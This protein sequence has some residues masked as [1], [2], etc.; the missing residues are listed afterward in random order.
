MRLLF[1]HPTILWRQN[2]E[3]GHKAFKAAVAAFADAGHECEVVSV[4]SHQA[5]DA[6][7]WHHLSSLP[8][9]GEGLIRFALAPPSWREVRFAALVRRRVDEWR[10]DRVIL[11]CG[12]MDARIALLLAGQ[13]LAMSVNTTAALPFGPR[14]ASKTKPWSHLPFGRMPRIFCAS[15]YIRDYIRAH[16]GVDAFVQPPLAYGKGPYPLCGS[17][18]PA[19]ITMINPIPHKGS[20]VFA[21]LARRYPDRKFRA[22]R[23][24]GDEPAELKRLSNVEI[25]PP[26]A[27]LDDVM[28]D[29]TV[30][31]VPSMWGEGWANVCVDA[32]LRGVPVLASDD[33]GLAEGTLGIGRCVPTLP[34]RVRLGAGRAVHF[35]E[36]RIDLDAWAR[37]L[38]TLVGDRAAWEARSRTS[39]AA[40]LAF[41]ESLSVDKLASYLAA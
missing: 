28:R 24:Y 6:S 14:S 26:S 21:R 41:L 35:K 20:A 19:R 34:G 3:G 39:R 15:R 5:P 10:P 17:F 40:A 4:A 11:E 30:L 29:T 22:Q 2:H 38:D 16:A 31:L 12:T 13:R 7:A 18:E 32:M 8:T 9:T 27:T 37:E 33:G 25:L 23:T 1:A 36:P